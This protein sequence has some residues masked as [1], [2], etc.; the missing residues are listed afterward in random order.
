MSMGVGQP[1]RV[2]Y[3]AL[4]LALAACRKSP[5]VGNA[6]PSASATGSAAPPAAPFSNRAV[7]GEAAFDLVTV[8]GG[9]AIAWG[10]TT[11]TGSE[12]SIA[13]TDA[14]GVPRGE[15]A[16]IAAP[17]K[18]AAG[19]A[20]EVG[21][22]SAGTR[23]GL[24]WLAR[25]PGGG[26]VFASVG[27]PETHT[28]A[29][30]NALFDSALGDTS[31]RGHLVVAAGGDSELMVLARGPD[32]LCLTEKGRT[33]ASFG[34]REIGSTPPERRG[35]PLAVPG[36]CSR[37]LVGFALIHDRWHYAVCS[38]DGAGAT[39]TAFNVQRKPYYAEAKKLLTGCTPLG[40]TVLGD[41]VVIAG[42]CADG[43]RA[44]RLGGMSDPVTSVELDKGELACERGRPVLKALG[45][46]PLVLVLDT[47]HDGLAPLLPPS[48]A[49]R[50]ARAV[51]TGT[52]LLVA[53]WIE[54][55][56][57]LHRYE[58]RGSELV[59]F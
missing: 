44:M 10:R 49:P 33:C 4:A 7:S 23:V 1:R 12:V 43:R 25:A 42:Q 26:A 57:A 9:A 39:V 40:M 29:V 27:D 46:P 11:K 30:P 51:W 6:T 56:L 2:L 22:A 8:S 32:E 45:A 16:V 50:N 52:T 14:R 59:R 36:A 31:Q 18:S 24:A 47:P 48:I 3:L 53:T 13:F 17:T 41:E 37:P 5:D 28:F 38:E 21:L 54:N 35:L 34:F 58:C 15:P 19:S 20:V 55:E